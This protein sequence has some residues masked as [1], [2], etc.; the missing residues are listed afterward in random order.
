[1]V[2]L[3]PTYELFLHFYYF[4]R[5]VS[6]LNTLLDTKVFEWKLFDCCFLKR[7]SLVEP[8][9]QLR[10]INMMWTQWTVLKYFLHQAWL[11]SENYVICFIFWFSLNSDV[12]EWM[13]LKCSDSTKHL[14][15]R[16]A[17]PTEPPQQV[18]S[19]VIPAIQVCIPGESQQ[20]PLTTHVFQF[21]IT[22]KHFSFIKI[23]NRNFKVCFRVS[24]DVSPFK[25]FPTNLFQV[26]IVQCLQETWNIFQNY[27]FAL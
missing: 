25:S 20:Q 7:V 11:T 15:T 2:T 4:L 22:S 18:S 26:V 6:V 24:A 16:W 1:M 5:V 10:Q 19:Y 27:F 8:S 3:H 14:L 12:S 21:L 9:R 13:I 23:V 17:L